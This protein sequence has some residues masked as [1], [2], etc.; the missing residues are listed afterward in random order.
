MLGLHE[1]LNYYEGF[2]FKNQCAAELFSHVKLLCFKL[3]NQVPLTKYIFKMVSES[4]V[5]T[6]YDHNMQ[7][8]ELL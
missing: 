8:L 4:V 3:W 5:K 1:C 2:L 6:S 7:V